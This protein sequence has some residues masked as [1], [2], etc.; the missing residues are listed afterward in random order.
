MY[1]SDPSVVALWHFGDEPVRRWAGSNLREYI[2]V[3]CGIH[4][5]CTSTERPLMVLTLRRILADLTRGYY[6]SIV[7][8]AYNTATT[9][10][11]RSIP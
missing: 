2:Y 3:P 6:V 11:K 5:G 7:I 8:L 10:L 1:F 4:D 9:P